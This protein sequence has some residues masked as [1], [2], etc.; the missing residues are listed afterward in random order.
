[1]SYSRVCPLQP[2]SSLGF[3]SLGFVSL[4]FVHS[5]VCR[6]TI[7]GEYLPKERKECYLS[8]TLPAI[9]IKPNFIWLLILST[10]SPLCSHYNLNISFRYKLFS[11]FNQEDYWKLESVFRISIS[12]FQELRPLYSNLVSAVVPK[13]VLHKHHQHR[14]PHCAVLPVLGRQ[15]WQQLQILFTLQNTAL[16][17]E[18]RG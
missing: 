14:H 15:P 8:S 18:V 4:G 16:Q 3:V 1:M 7:I 12:I 6:I 5:R 11:N 13:A 10:T 9:F 2:L 17:E